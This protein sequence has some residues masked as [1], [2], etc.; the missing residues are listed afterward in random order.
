VETLLAAHESSVFVYSSAVYHWGLF[1][2]HSTITVAN[3]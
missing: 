1:V 3:T 2:I